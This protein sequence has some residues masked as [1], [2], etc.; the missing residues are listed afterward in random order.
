MDIAQLQV[1]AFMKLAGQTCPEKPIAPDVSICTLRVKLLLEEVL[2]LAAAS[3]VEVFAEGVSL[4]KA[5]A[6]GNVEYKPDGI[7]DLIGVGDGLADIKYVNEGAA[8]AFG[9]DLE[10]IFNEVQRSNMT[11][12]WTILDLQSLVYSDGKIFFDDKPVTIKQLDH[13]VD[14]ERKYGVYDASGKLLKSPTY[15][16]ANLQPIIEAQLHA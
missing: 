9:L 6:N 16:R 1:K 13:P 8:N 11:K 2:E 15:E 14:P 12:A 4:H 7:V 10:P 3:G 5:F